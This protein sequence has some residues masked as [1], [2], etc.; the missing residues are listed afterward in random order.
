MEV[1]GFRVACICICTCICHGM[2]WPANLSKIQGNVS[3]GLE[4]FPRCNKHER[5]RGG[6]ARPFSPW[7]YSTQHQHY[8]FAP[9][10]PITPPPPF[11]STTLGLAFRATIAVIFHHPVHTES[12]ILLLLSLPSIRL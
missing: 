10:S 6:T 3:P 7:R 8:C 12:F 1:C 4:A 11:C 5:D 9:S 2:A